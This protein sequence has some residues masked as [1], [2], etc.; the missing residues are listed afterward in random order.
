MITNL[1]LKSLE[2]DATD[3]AFREVGGFLLEDVL[4]PA[5]VSN[6][7]AGLTSTFANEE[8]LKQL[9]YDK[10][11]MVGY[12]PPGVEGTKAEGPN[13]RRHFIDYRTTQF[14]TIEPPLH[15]LCSKLLGLGRHMLQM[16][17]YEA[18]K[19][20]EWG[21]HLFRATQYL[22]DEIDPDVILFP[23]HIDFGLLTFFI[24]TPDQGLQVELDGEWHD[25]IVLPGQ[26][27]VG[28]GSVLR[29]YRPDF[30]ALRHRV[31]ARSARRMSVFLFLEPGESVRLPS[32]ES[33]P[34]FLGRLLRKIRTDHQ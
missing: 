29:Q 21:E 12:T 5:L 27:L 10:T 9:R 1:S 17:S 22:N 4:D 14:K 2:A 34:E 19:A 8:E 6:V 33:W 23:S 13:F 32:G 7:L 28:V 11:R 26:V 18:V 15:M 30:R 24:G 16:A 25:A 20:G 31:T 3:H